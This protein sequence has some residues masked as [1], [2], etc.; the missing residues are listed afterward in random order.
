M[1]DDEIIFLKNKELEDIEYVLSELEKNSFVHIN[2]NVYIIDKNTRDE[3][4]YL[5]Q[6]ILGIRG[7]IEETEYKKR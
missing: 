6:K 3:L 1:F 5:I 2:G 4:E 7:C